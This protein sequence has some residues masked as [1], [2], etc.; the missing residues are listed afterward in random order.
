MDL[1]A[2]SFQRE[3]REVISKTMFQDSNMA[4]ALGSDMKHLR[5][6]AYGQ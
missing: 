3:A 2:L 5:P 6:P 1:E 4:G